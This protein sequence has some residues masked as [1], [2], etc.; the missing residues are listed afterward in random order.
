MAPKGGSDN[1]FSDF[2]FLKS[3]LEAGIDENE[4][5][6]FSF[7]VE[8]PHDGIMRGTSS[9]SAEGIVAVPHSEAGHFE[10]EEDFDFDNVS[11]PEME[12]SN[13]TINSSYGNENEAKIR[14]TIHLGESAG[15]GNEYS[16]EFELSG[17]GSI[18]TKDWSS[19]QR[20]QAEEHENYDNAWDMFDSP[21]GVG[22]VQALDNP[23]MIG[24][25]V[26][27]VIAAFPS[28]SLLELNEQTN[29]FEDGPKLPH[30][31]VDGT[32]AKFEITTIP[33]NF[34]IDSEHFEDTYDWSIEP[35]ADSENPG[36][37]P[38][39]DS[40]LIDKDQSVM[41]VEN[42]KWFADPDNQWLNETGVISTYRIS[43]NVA[44][45]ITIRNMPWT[46]G[47]EYTGEINPRQMLL[48]GPETE[49]VD[50]FWVVTGIGSHER[51]T[52][53]I[54]PVVYAPIE[55]QFY[56]KID[57]HEMYHIKQYT[58]IYPFDQIFSSFKTRT[59]GGPPI[60][61]KEEYDLVNNMGHKDEQSF[62]FAVDLAYNEWQNGYSQM[63]ANTRCELEWQAH[64]HIHNIDP[65]YLNLQKDEIPGIYGC[66]F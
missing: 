66:T 25:H 47:V 27:Q 63:R 50:G 23:E 34:F 37:D 18:Q 11:W 46:V 65:Q 6:T 64:E 39:A 14:V 8:I 35:G 51:D 56:S 1:D 42:A 49:R 10:S 62:R 9:D 44:N 58:E 12:A 15:G 28:D 19:H 38:L 5:Y 3:L 22:Q 4:T 40:D 30:F 41:T 17:A 54:I 52:S 16:T 53:Q 60:S 21:D 61:L 43:V 13:W 48:G 45:A 29:R 24:L 32:E 31:S 57:A 2:Y 36:N 26:V 59:N 20:A 55:S 33:D 7:V